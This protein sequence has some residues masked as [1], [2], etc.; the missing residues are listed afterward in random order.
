MQLARAFRHTDS[1][2]AILE[3]DDG[4]FVDVNPA[5]ER[6]LGWTRDEVKNVL[7]IPFK[8]L[9]RDP[10]VAIYGGTPWEPWS[11]TLAA[12]RFLKELQRI[13]KKL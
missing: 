5:F 6:I 9:E 8:P 7:K 1:I 11:P 2:V 4:S 12:E 13:Q 3:R 10:L